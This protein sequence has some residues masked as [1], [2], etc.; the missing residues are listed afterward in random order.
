[1]GR[2]PAAFY[3]A[4]AVAAVTVCCFCRT[5]APLAV[6]QLHSSTTTLSNV[7][8]SLH[9]PAPSKAHVFEELSLIVNNKNNA[10]SIHSDRYRRDPTFVLAAPYFIFTSNQLISVYAFLTIPSLFQAVNELLESLGAP[11]EIVDGFVSSIAVTIPWQA[12]L[13]D[14]CTLEVSGLQITCRPKYRT[15][16]FSVKQLPLPNYRLPCFRCSASFIICLKFQTFP[17]FSNQVY[18]LA[19]A[20]VPF[21]RECVESNCYGSQSFVISQR[22]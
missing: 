2:G 1:M 15:S 19:F 16:E 3:F 10:D 11:L 21:P 17:V 9:R 14:H 6:S 8:S 20:Y 7:I 5:R 22:N 4:L 13:T 18:T 12:L